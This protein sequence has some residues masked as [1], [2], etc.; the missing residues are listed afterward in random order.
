MAAIDAPSLTR[1]TQ[2][3]PTLKSM[4]ALRAPHESS[5]AINGVVLTHASAADSL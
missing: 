2:K 5:V 4:T 3:P 1:A